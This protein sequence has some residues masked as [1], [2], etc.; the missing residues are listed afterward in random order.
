M[1]KAKK[2]FLISLSLL[3]FSAVLLFSIFFIP[4][5]LSIRKIVRN[6]DD[7]KRI[8][9]EIIE[10]KNDLDSLKESLSS[11]DAHIKKIQERLIT[12]DNLENIVIALEKLAESV[13]VKQEIL[14][15]QPQAAA[16]GTVYFKNIITGNFENVMRY[17]KGAENLKYIAEINSCNFS[18]ILSGEIKAEITLA[19]PVYKNNSN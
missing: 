18:K 19:V 17:A 4:N 1:N 7:R 9:S 3:S 13:T 15:K 12:E 16:A 14:L 11:S 8:S 6:M 2:E 5:A 10:R